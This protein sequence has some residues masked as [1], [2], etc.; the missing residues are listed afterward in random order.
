MEVPEGPIFGSILVN[1]FLCEMFLVID[2]VDIVIYADNSTSYSVGKNQ[3]ELENKIQ[4]ESV[5]TFKLKLLKITRINVIFC[6]ELT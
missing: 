4:K 5:K 6:Q 1:I 2:T 3:C